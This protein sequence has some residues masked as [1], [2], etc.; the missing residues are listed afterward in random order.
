MD[1]TTDPATVARA[2]GYPYPPAPRPV[3]VTPRGVSPLPDPAP[4]ALLAEGRGAVI[5]AGANAAPQR[6]AEKLAD[7]APDVPL[8]PAWLHGHAVVYSAHISRYGAVPATLLPCPGGRS[9]VAVLFVTPDELARLHDSE[10]LGENYRFTRLHGL[11]LELAAGGRLRAAGAYLSLHGP[12]MPGGAPVAVA[13]VPAEG[14]PHA[15]LSQ[16]EVQRAVM[17]MVAATG[18]V[19]GFICANTADAALRARRIRR[20]KAARAAGA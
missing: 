7:L 2:L 20:M 13:A 4:E 10:A 16:A 12:L 9:R 1:P 18:D 6:L 8:V 11:R 14:V 15:R 3:R 19:A 17:G 5:A